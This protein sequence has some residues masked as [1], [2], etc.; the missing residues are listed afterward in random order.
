M[1]I[2]KIRKQGKKYL[3]ELEDGTIIKTY[4][5]ILIKYN[6]LYH[7]EL[8]EEMFDKIS[9]ENIYYDAYNSCLTYI[10][11]KLRSEYENLIVSIGNNQIRENITNYAIELGYK[12]PN[13]FN[14]TAYISPYAKFGYGCIVLSNASIQNGAVLHNGIV[15]TANVEVHHDCE[16]DDYSLVY[17]NSTIRTNAYVG[18]R[19]KIESNITVPNNFKVEI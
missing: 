7:K 17:S 16:L 5:D 19:V 9:K 2:N 13:I 1:K 4:G 12:I 15:I 8:D 11:K 3:I 10:S 18:K 6:I 14:E